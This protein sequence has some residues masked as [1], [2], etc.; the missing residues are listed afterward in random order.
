MNNVNTNVL[1][2]EQ[3]RD[4]VEALEAVAHR[5]ARERAEEAD[6]RALLPASARNIVYIVS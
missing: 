6:Q 4:L 5:S 2:V 1:E 3:Q